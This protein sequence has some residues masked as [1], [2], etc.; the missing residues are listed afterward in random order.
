MS[1]Q[2]HHPHICMQASQALAGTALAC[3]MAAPHL[4]WGFCF[5]QDQQYA[6]QWVQENA[7]AFGGDPTKVLPSPL[8]ACSSIRGLQWGTVLP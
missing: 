6:L 1:Q 7:A 2:V 8:A 5:W 3:D 4:T